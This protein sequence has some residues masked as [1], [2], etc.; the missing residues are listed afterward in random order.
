M[1]VKQHNS[2]LSNVQYS[3]GLEVN[4]Q[5]EDHFLTFV[6][7]LYN[8]AS[9]V[10]H[11]KP[12]SQISIVHKIMHLVKGRCT[13]GVFMSTLVDY[14]MIRLNLDI[15]EVNVAT[16]DEFHRPTTSHEHESYIEMADDTMVRKQSA[17]LPITL[18][19]LPNQDGQKRAG[20]IVNVPLML[21][22]LNS[23]NVTLYALNKERV[24][25]LLT[26][27]PRSLSTNYAHAPNTDSPLDNTKNNTLLTNSDSTQ[28]LK[29]KLLKLFDRKSARINDEDAMSCSS[30]DLIPSNHQGAVQNRNDSPL[31]GGVGG[32]DDECD[33]FYVHPDT[34][35]STRSAIDRENK[36][37]AYL[38]ALRSFKIGTTSLFCIWNIMERILTLDAWSMNADTTDSIVDPPTIDDEGAACII[39][40]D[41]VTTIKGPFK[42]RT[43]VKRCASSLNSSFN[44]ILP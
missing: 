20:V 43:N 30:V 6:H 16:K 4:D 24:R 3:V 21:R 27:L 7:C 10:P 39:R 5:F 35:Y 44:F 13:F 26:E 14:Y 32:I 36:I 33:I 37:S 29:C 34:H 1:N 17:N 22:L 28:T 11:N 2:K 40:I 42:A 15:L 12:D 31:R 18:L 19:R 23:I 38:N 25:I 9:W 8:H 41:T